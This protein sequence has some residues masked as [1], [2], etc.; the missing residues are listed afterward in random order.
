MDYHALPKEAQDVLRR[1]E[2]GRD[3]NYPQ[4]GSIFHN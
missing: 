3:F 4:D 1:V 2:E